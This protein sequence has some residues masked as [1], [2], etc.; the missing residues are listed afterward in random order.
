MGRKPVL[1]RFDGFKC[2]IL[3]GPDETGV[4]CFTD[5]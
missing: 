5:P 1:L 2:R 3:V 4:A